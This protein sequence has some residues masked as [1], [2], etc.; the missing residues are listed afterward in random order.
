MSGPS[1][2]CTPWRL[3]EACDQDC[4]AN[5]VPYDRRGIEGCATVECLPVRECDAAR[6]L[7]KRVKERFDPGFSVVLG[8]RLIIEPPLW[9]SVP[10]ISLARSM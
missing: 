4:R 9:M 1:F 6:A 7:A 2:G 8:I 10:L 5:S 3:A